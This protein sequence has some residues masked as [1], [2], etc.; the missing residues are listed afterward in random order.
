M[1]PR[2]RLY[3]YSFKSLDRNSCHRIRARGYSDISRYA[4]VVDSVQ[5]RIPDSFNSLILASLASVIVGAIFERRNMVF[6]GSSVLIYSTTVLQY[7]TNSQSSPAKAT[8]A[9]AG[10]GAVDESPE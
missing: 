3:L 2:P 4:N 7:S 6:F 9:F 1:E 8:C 5:I 10:T